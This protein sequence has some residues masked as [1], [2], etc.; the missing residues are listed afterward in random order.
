MS[1]IADTLLTPGDTLTFNTTLTNH[2]DSTMSP[3]LFVYGTT[4]GPDSFTFLAVDTTEIAVLPPAG[5]KRDITDLEVPVNAPFGHYVFTAYV[6]S[7]VTDST[8][9]DDPFGFQV[10]GQAMPGHGGNELASAGRD[11]GPW[12]VLSGWFGYN[13]RQ[14][15]QAGIIPSSSTIPKTF[16]MAQNYPN[17]F[18]PSTTIRYEVPQGRPSVHV[19]ITIYDLRGRR[20]RT[21]VD[22][23]KEPG[24]YQVHWDGRDAAE[25]KVPSGVYLYKIMAGDFLSTRKMV[26]VR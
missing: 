21:L 23:E 12:K 16:S 1:P 15:G 25:K 13:E 10:G 4:T 9:D 22:E 17:P 24:I 11:M 3:K 18:N 7:P 8:F 26:V 2:S 19:E 20:V 14:Q 5:R 6:V